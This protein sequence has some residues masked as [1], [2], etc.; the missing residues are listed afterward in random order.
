MIN[1]VVPMLLTA[2]R[3]YV[4]N[5][6]RFDGTNDYLR[7][8]SNFTGGATS[9]KTGIMSGWFNLKGGDGSL[10]IA[11]GQDAG[12]GQFERTTG[13]KWRLFLYDVAGS[14]ISLNI[15]SN[16]TYTTASGWHHVL[17]A[18]NVASGIAQMYINDASDVTGSPTALNN[19]LEYSRLDLSWGA[20][21]VGG[22]KLNADVADF[23]F[24]TDTTLDISVTANRR[25]FITA[26]LKPVYLGTTGQLP[27]GA[28]PQIYLTNPFSSW[29]TNAAGNGNY[30][31]TGALTAGDSSPSN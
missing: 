15:T 14:A 8:T 29:Q 24:N 7:R 31:V 18:W 10:Q 23:Y 1:Q 17:I 11:W 22:S 3:R 19:T 27:T 30:T 25:K 13:N 2:S 12:Y 21:K 6:T 16:N 20:N 4:A 26:G 9:G 28:T 5:S